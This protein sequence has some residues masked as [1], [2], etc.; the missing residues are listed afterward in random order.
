MAEP[1]DWTVKYVMTVYGFRSLATTVMRSWELRTLP[2]SR[3]D[4]R[5]SPAIMII[6]EPTQA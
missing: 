3:K 5:A 1:V 2:G 6:D 4:T